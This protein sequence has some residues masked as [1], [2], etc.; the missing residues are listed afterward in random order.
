MAISLYDVSVGQYLQ[1]LGAT[2]GVLERAEKHCRE[3]GGDP[4]A[5]VGARLAEDMFPLAFQIRSVAHHSVGALEGAK[6]GLFHPPSGPMPQTYAELHATVADAI[7]ALKAMTPD[8]VS[9]LEGRDMV[10]KL[11]EMEMPFVVEGFLLSFSLPNFYFHATTAYGIL[12]ANG[13]PLG[14]R[15]FLG[16]L[17][18][19]TA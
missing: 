14:K 7:A 19:K 11:G 5:L 18:L 2:A 9:A 17:K 8:E 3:A 12:R 6:T 13:A 16:A 4:D 1:T 10:F 15:N